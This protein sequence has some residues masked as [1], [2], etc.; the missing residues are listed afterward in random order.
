MPWAQALQPAVGGHRESFDSLVV[1]LLMQALS[2]VLL[3]LAFP[4][5]G[6]WLLAFVALAPAAWIAVRTHKPWRLAWTSYLV[7]SIWWLVMIG[8]LMPV[9]EGGYALLALYMALY[10]PASLLVLRWIHD[11]IHSSAVLVLPMVWCSFEIIRSQF[12]QGG[13]GWF[14][15]G[16]AIA[17]HEPSPAA[18]RLIQ[19]ADLFG[20]HSVSFFVAM[21]SGLIVD[22]LIPRRLV[23]QR[24]ASVLLW[25]LAFLGAWLYGEFRVRETAT[26][27][28]QSLRVAVVQT[29]NPIDNSQDEGKDA[30]IAEWSRLYG[31]T[32][33]AA[34]PKGG[35]SPALV[36][37]PESA[38][39]MP[40]N[41]QALSRLPDSR[42]FDIQ[43]RDL[44]KVIDTHLLVGAPASEGWAPVMIEGVP[45]E[46]STSRYNSAYL[47]RPD[48]SQFPERYDKMHLVPFGEYIPWAQ[49][50]PWLKQLF[51]KHLSPY[52]FDYTIARGD[53]PEIFPL[54][55]VL[56]DEDTGRSPRIATPICFED[57]IPDVCRRMVY[58][59]DGGK[60]VDL[61][62]NLT[63][64]GWYPGFHQGAQ[65]MQLAVLRCVENR[66]P[67]A[68]SVNTGVSGFISSLGQVGPVVEVNGARQLVEGFAVHDM[69]FDPRETF[70][71]RFGHAPI[72]CLAVF[73]GLLAVA[74]FWFP[75][76]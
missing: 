65:H 75:R 5:P 29:N 61:L 71:G 25:L 22:L 70:F 73:T 12:L 67:M 45:Y 20:Q 49:D 10:T 72:W 57:S 3:A 14:A 32:L 11:R 66:V 6:W 64:D 76:S 54:A 50:W 31:L 16:H 51:I 46:Q 34:S 62:C 53:A 2:A 35:R 4:K 43:L 40:L 26:L 52:A 8:W 30:W 39:P 24:S 59:A 23:R 15:L 55:G 33:E 38:V 28:Q 7:A 56:R 68:R 21:S 36:V 9:T 19:I 13:F 48:G 44:V 47:Y 42:G 18:P 41:P 74:G 69:L 27:T 17:P 58:E 1:H 60:R 63:N 37:W